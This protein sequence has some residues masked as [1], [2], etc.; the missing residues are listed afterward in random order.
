MD[1]LQLLLQLAL[2]AV[3]GEELVLDEGLDFEGL[4]LGGDGEGVDVWE[5]FWLWW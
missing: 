5:W 2:L 1:V 3:E 4:L